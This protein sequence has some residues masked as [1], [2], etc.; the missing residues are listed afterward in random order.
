MERVTVKGPK[1]QYIT[2]SGFKPRPLSAD[3]STQTTGIHK[4]LLNKILTTPN[5]GK[6]PHESVSHSSLLVHFLSAGW[7]DARWPFDSMTQMR[8]G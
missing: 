7:I 3:S 1:T 4:N 2:G 8:A 5:S 6:K